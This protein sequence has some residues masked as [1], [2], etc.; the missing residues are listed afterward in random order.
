MPFTS[1]SVKLMLE[2]FR[3]QFP[4]DIYLIGLL[5]NDTYKALSVVKVKHSKNG[6]FIKHKSST[7]T[8]KW[9]TNTKSME[10]AFQPHR[11]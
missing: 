2:L 4:E 6:S 8:T 3:L 11:Q 1:F 5:I 10:T 7:V 9:A